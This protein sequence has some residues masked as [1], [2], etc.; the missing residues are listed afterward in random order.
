MI[1]NDVD[2]LIAGSGGGGLA[3]AL[4][5]SSFGLKVMICEKSRYVGGTTAISGGSAWAIATVQE[6]Q[7]GLQD[8]IETGRRYLDAMGEGHGSGEMQDAFL[9]AA[10]AAFAFL[11]HQTDVTF[12]APRIH[13]DYYPHL[14]GTTTGGRNLGPDTLDGRRLG[15]LINL[16]RPP[17]PEFT[18][19]FG[20]AVARSEISDLVRPWRSIR[21]FRLA[22]RA[23]LGHAWALLFHRR[24]MRLLMGNALIGRLLLSLAARGVTPALETSVA[25]LWVEN[26]QIAGAVLRTKTG[27]KHVRA[28][29]GVV[30]ATGGFA[31]NADMRQSMLG[32]LQTDHFVTFEGAA[33]D[34]IVLA[35]AVGAGLAGGSA[36][37]GLWMPAS[38][39]RRQGKR[40][41]TFPHLRDRAKPGLIAVGSDGRRFVNEANSYHDVCL[42]MFRSK[43]HGETVEAHLI[44]DHAFIREFG[45]GLIRPFWSR[46]RPFIAS[47][48]LAKGRTLAE[49][50]RKIGVDPEGLQ[51]TV[52]RHNADAV[53]GTDTE[54]AKGGS[55]LNRLN[56]D[57]RFKPNPC[58]API[59]KAPFYAVRVVPALL[60]TARGLA[61]DTEARVLDQNRRPIKG[62]YAVGNDMASVFDG[63][64]PG[65]G[66]TIGPAIAFAW[67]AACHAA[68]RDVATDRAAQN[69]IV[70]E[71]EHHG[72]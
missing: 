20:M 42:A 49:L 69:G 34:G 28:R 1:D 62:L 53:S 57:E 59:G 25:R 47:G 21:A 40:D 2:L 44:C 52:A 68:K 63:H 66:A 23:V 43:K 15:S 48:Y 26:G 12:T 16:V 38:I 18:G 30:L 55:A 8:S 58:L 9:E 67:R 13:P 3:T 29:Q 45:L 22:T 10:P 27:E 6:E 64:Y 41:I 60:A 33:G 50:A 51:A 35:R 31:A 7:A 19:P 54:F 56:G 32:S 5:A 71:T 39:L 36:S 14:P 70:R 37:A 72:L 24:A 46:L 11:Q 17:R 4:F 61:T 65:P